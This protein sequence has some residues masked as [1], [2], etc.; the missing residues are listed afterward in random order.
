MATKE[1]EMAIW[2]INMAP[3]RNWGISL[4]GVSMLLCAAGISAAEDQSKD[5]DAELI[6]VAEAGESAGQTDPGQVEE[7]AVPRM[8]PGGTH[9]PPLKGGFVDGNRLRA[10]AGYTIDLRTDGV[11]MLRPTV[12]GKGP[13]GRCSCHSVNGTCTAERVD[14]TQVKCVGK[15]GCTTCS[16]IIDNPDIGGM[17]SIQ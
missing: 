9:M 10:T 1:D 3:T 15:S 14:E 12:G 8:G 17:K 6:M 11:F 13:T 4:L 2:S 16:I 7:R 5:C